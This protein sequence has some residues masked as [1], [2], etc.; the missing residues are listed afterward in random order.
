MDPVGVRRGGLRGL[1]PR[2]RRDLLR[3]APFG[4][5]WVVMA[6]VFLI[7][8]YAAAGS[9]SNVPESA[10]VLDPAIYVFATI[11]V[12]LV[13]LVVG[14]VEL[15]FLNRRFAARSLATKLFGKTAFYVALLLVVV[16]VTFPI[17]AAME[18]NTSLF[19]PRVGDRLADFLISKTGLATAIQ[20][21]TS[22]VLSISYAEISEHMG[23]HVLASFLTGRYHTPRAEER[24]FLFSDMKSS[25]AITER[26][27]HAEYFHFL[28]AYYGALSG[29]IVEYGG[30]VYQYIGDE[31]VV[32][33]R[34]EA[35]LHEGACI[36]CLLRM[37]TDLAAA[38]GDFERRFGVVPAFY[39]GL[40]LGPVTTG[41]VGALKKE[42]VFT[43]DVLN[44]AARIQALCRT[45]GTDALVGG[46]LATALPPTDAL[47]LRSVG[48]FELRGKDH[49]VELF[50]LAGEDGAPTSR[51]S[52]G[53]ER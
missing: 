38:G 49:E 31:I 32:T 5:I 17:A 29:A 35:G 3:V 21:T 40:Q 53:R 15:L 9:F 45:V 28:K 52:M 22:L 36:R 16:L 10:I 47:S 48:S 41:E 39:A 14:A 20:L 26:L 11:A 23:P 34:R 18:M 42:I 25:T 1:S 51:G 30:E 43:G 44:Q 24:V 13:G 12:G 37:Q 50:T 19:D 7:S 2:A 8:D 27:G 4:V 33:W 46:D 6:Q